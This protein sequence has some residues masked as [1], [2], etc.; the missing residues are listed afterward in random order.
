MVVGV[1][2]GA[3]GRRFQ[4]ASPDRSERARL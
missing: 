2:V 3:G 4:S 1:H